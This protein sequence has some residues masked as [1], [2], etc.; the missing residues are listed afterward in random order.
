MDNLLKMEF[1]IKN[2]KFAKNGRF[3][4]NGNFEKKWKISLTKLKLQKTFVNKKIYGIILFGP[5]ENSLEI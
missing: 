1:S 4:K 3:L 5:V 2:G